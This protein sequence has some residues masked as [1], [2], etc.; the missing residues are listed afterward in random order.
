MR[1]LRGGRGRRRKRHL[2]WNADSLAGGKLLR[3]LDVVVARE[4]PEF[5]CVAKRPARDA[6]ECFAST[7]G[8]GLRLLAERSRRIGGDAPH[9]TGRLLVVRFELANLLQFG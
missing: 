8:V 2:R 1:W 6:D 9:Q 4:Q 3:D 7:D 5:A